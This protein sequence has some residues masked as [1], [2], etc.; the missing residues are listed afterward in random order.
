MRPITVIPRHPITE[1]ALSPDG[2]RLGVVQATHGFRLLDALTGAELGR[3]TERDKVS[4]VSPTGRHSMR[5]DRMAIRL[6]EVTAGRPFL[7]FQTGWT[8]AGNIN[9]PPVVPETSPLHSGAVVSWDTPPARRLLIFP[10]PMERVFLIASALTADHRFAVGRLS[11]GDMRYAVRDL[12]T[13]SIIATLDITTSPPGSIH[14]RTVFTPDETAVVAVTTR[15]ILMFSLPAPEPLV[16]S[17]LDAVGARV[18]RVT[19]LAPGVVIHV[20]QPQPAPGI[21][22]FALLPC[23]RKA[24][25]RGERSRVE[26]RDLATGEVLTVWKWG[27]R[28]LHAL[29]VAADGLTAAAGGFRGEVVIWDLG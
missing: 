16:P 13:E 5:A 23:G 2:Q 9:C 17:P 28:R 10:P 25:V 29:A 6:A 24:I 12:A 18:T 26:L 22:P 4:E 27:L 7:R 21:P 1:L 15:T 8:R 19:P 14:I 11:H 20:T 3:D